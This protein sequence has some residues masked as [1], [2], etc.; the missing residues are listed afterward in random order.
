MTSE[1]ETAILIHDCIA[2][3]LHEDVFISPRSLKHC[4][5][6]VFPLDFNEYESFFITARQLDLIAM[7]APTPLGNSQAKAT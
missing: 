7:A 6:A 3:N 5:N 1:V 4:L 2:D